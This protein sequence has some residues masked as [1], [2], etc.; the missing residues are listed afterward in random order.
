MDGP[1]FINHR[2]ADFQSAARIAISDIIPY[3]VSHRH[4]VVDV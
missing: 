2:H 1:Q 4:I 3:S